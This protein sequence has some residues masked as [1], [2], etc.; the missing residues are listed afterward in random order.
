M[1][2][3]KSSREAC[4]SSIPPK[5]CT[6]LPYLNGYG[7]QYVKLPPATVTSPLIK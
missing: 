3:C 1:P 5:F 6:I 4:G 7:T 2:V